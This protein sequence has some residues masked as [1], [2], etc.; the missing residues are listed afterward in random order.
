MDA[1]PSGHSVTH[2]P[3][4]AGGH[5]SGKVCLYFYNGYDGDSISRK[6]FSESRG[7]WEC[8]NEPRKKNAS[9]LAE[10]RARRTGVSRTASITVSG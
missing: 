3:Y 9:E 4:G 10:E 5:S 6:S 8:G 2:A 1:Y 7:W